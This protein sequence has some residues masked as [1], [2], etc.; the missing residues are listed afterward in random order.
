M[1]EPVSRLQKGFFSQLNAQPSLLK[2]CVS[3]AF[4]DTK[5]HDQET[6]PSFIRQAIIDKENIVLNKKQ[7]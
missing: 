5:K 1:A 7:N 3:P 6:L 2:P 4:R